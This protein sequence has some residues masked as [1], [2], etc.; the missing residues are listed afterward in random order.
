ME[1]KKLNELKKGDCFIL[2]PIE[3]PKENQVWVRDHYNRDDKTFTCHSYD[4][5]NRE[6]FFKS[7]K[8]VFVGFTF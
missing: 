5:L 1:Q 6:R 3:E 8:V 4:D 7:S 2:K